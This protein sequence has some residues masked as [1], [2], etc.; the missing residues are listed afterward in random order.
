[1][2]LTNLKGNFPDA[3][4]FF[5]RTSNGAE[6]DFVVVLRNRVY[7]IECKSSQK[8]SLAKGNYLAIDDISPKETFVVA[9]I[10]QG[11]SLKPGIEVVSLTELLI[12]LS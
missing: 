12:R 9:P 8:P 1:M 6:I 3:T 2:V 5:Y 7:A 11:W 10:N 4:V